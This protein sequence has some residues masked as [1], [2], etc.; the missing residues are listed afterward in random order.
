MDL[1]HLVLDPG[2]QPEVRTAPL[3]YDTIVATVGYP[4]EVIN[5]EGGRAVMY[6]CEEGKQK[7]MP[8]NEAA[9]KIAAGSLRNDDYISGTALVVGPMGPGGV[10][11]SLPTETLSDLLGLAE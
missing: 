7:G 3:T 11:T 10:D 9:T 6:V 2:G 1:Q 4:V 5:I 8:R